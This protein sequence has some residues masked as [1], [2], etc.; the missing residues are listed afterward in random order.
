MNTGKF[1]NG[2][3]IF[4]AL[5][6]KNPRVVAAYLGRGTAY[7]LMGNLEAVRISCLNIKIA[8]PLTCVCYVRHHGIFH[9][10]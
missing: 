5:L 3:K 8:V 10:P 4:N 7:A 1:E 2:I 9:P 6:A